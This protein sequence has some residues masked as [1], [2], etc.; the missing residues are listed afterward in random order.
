MN[1]PTGVE[2]SYNEL[3]LNNNKEQTTDTTIWIN[4]KCIILSEQSQSQ[5]ATYR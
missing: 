3:H 1:G 5:M 4:V 2:H